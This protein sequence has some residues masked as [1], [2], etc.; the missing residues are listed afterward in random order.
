M[1]KQYQI[2]GLNKL[3]NS[4]VI[5]GIYPMVDRIEISDDSLYFRLDIDIFLNDPDIT[6]Y[7]MYEMGFDPHYLIDYHLK[8]YFPYFNLDRELFYFHSIIWGPNGDIVVS[9]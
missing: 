9:F 4:E 1:T 6:R 2:D 8:N 3:V 5:K 7:N